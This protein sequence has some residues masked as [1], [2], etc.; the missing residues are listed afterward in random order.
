MKKRGFYRAS[1]PTNGRNS[2]VTRASESTDNNQIRGKQ[3]ENKHDAGDSYKM[4]G[5]LYTTDWTLESLESVYVKEDRR[6][7]TQEV[8]KTVQNTEKPKLRKRKLPNKKQKANTECPQVVSKSRFP[9]SSATVS[10]SVDFVT[11][12][13][14]NGENTLV[15]RSTQRL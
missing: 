11:K 8:N 5:G 3:E 15:S 14:E 6:R 4:Y 12:S 7:A 9:I 1:S 10:S 2:A 13:K